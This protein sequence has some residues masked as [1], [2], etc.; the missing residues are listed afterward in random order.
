MCIYVT[1]DLWKKDWIWWHQKETTLDVDH[2]SVIDRVL[3]NADVSLNKC[4]MCCNWW[5]KYDDRE[6]CRIS[7]TY[8]KWPKLSHVSAHLL[9]YSSWTPD[10]QIFQGRRCY[11]I[12]HWNCQFSMLKMGRSTDC[13]E[14]LLKNWS[15]KRNLMML[16][17]SIVK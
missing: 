16:H 11:E 8:E 12:C 14:I 7:C 17:D 6:K 15:L 4:T 1:S 10:R 2:K 9:H 13:L 3:R 5:S